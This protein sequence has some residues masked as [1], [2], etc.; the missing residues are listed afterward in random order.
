MWDPHSGHSSGWE[1]NQQMLFGGRS[2]EAKSCL[3][4]PAANSRSSSQP[5]GGATHIGE[6]NTLRFGANEK[7]PLTPRQVIA[8]LT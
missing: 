6:L 3:A 5:R 8:S 1:L 2:P 4:Q 7:I